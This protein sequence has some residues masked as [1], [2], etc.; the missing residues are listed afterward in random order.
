MLFWQK[1]ISFNPTAIWPHWRALIFPVCIPA[2]LIWKMHN[3]SGL[4]VCVCVAACEVIDDSYEH[5]CRFG[6][7]CQLSCICLL[8]WCV[9]LALFFVYCRFLIP[10]RKK[11]R[12]KIITTTKNSK[13]LI[14][15]RQNMDDDDKSVHNTWKQQQQH[16]GLLIHT[17]IL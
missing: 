11:K 4:Y 3:N 7:C 13:S 10:I 5:F 8:R 1:I 12:A 14:I 9:R 6:C 15:I 16:E 2:S 17:H